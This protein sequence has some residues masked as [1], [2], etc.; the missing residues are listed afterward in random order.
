VLRRPLVALLVAALL[1]L[2]PPSATSAGGADPGDALEDAHVRASERAAERGRDPRLHRRIYVSRDSQAYR[3]ATRDPRFR[4]IGRQPIAQIVSENWFPMGTVTRQVR[5]YA[6]KANRSGRT[7]LLAIYAIP[8]RDCGGY[9]AGGLD[10]ASY[11]TWVARIAR[12][13]RGR[14]AMVIL[15]PDALGHLGMC[16]GQGDRTGT[17]AYATRV[18]TAAGAWVYIDA[19]HSA[20][21]K[22]H[23][24]AERLIRSG[25]R[26]ARGFAVNV[27]SFV[28]TRLEKRYATRILTALRK[29]GVGPKH[30]VMDTSRNG[31]GQRDGN[32]WCNPLYARLGRAPEVVAQRR[33]DAYLWVKA[34]G[35]SDG[36]CNGGPYAGAWWPEYALRLMGR[37]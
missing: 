30:Y 13:L 12:G 9:S 4:P 27:A 15:E 34:P 7:P 29:R 26:H 32:D 6:K 24:M 11:K 35:E 8:G 23:V 36:Y 2:A 37:H 18:L 21:I 10:H 17:L 28:D 33:L 1:A 22:P 14:H 25:V 16:G 3:A 31:N 20:W 19:A 5:A